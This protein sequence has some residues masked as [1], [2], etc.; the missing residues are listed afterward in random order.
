MLAS[1]L[2]RLCYK[3]WQERLT[4]DE[5]LSQ[6]LYYYWIKLM[7]ESPNLNHLKINHQV[8]CCKPIFIEFHEF[9]MH[10]TQLTEVAS[11]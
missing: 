4:W 6:N 2:P 9:Q 7:D 10:Q 1:L 3:L 5:P 11:I 8:I